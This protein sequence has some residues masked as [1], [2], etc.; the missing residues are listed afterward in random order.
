M[1]DNNMTLWYMVKQQDLCIHLHP[2]GMVMARPS[3][4]HLAG[5]CAAMV[6][7]HDCK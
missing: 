7:A 3:G 5:A 6:R 4:L 2:F 1:L